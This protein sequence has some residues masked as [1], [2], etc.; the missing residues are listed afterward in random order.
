MKKY[1]NPHILKA[2]LNEQKEK[3]WD[4]R[5]TNLKITEYNSFR[6]I[7]YISLGLIKAKLK[8]EKNEEKKLKRAYSI[9]DSTLNS[10]TKIPSPN[11]GHDTLTNKDSLN[12]YSISKISPRKYQINYNNIKNKKSIY[13]NTIPNSCRKTKEDNINNKIIT[14]KYSLSPLYKVKNDSFKENNNKKIKNIL[15]DDIV[16]KI[17]GDE[18]IN[19]LYKEVKELWNEY[20]VSNIYQNK[21]LSSLNNYFL[22]KKLLYEFLIIEKNYMLK[23]KNEYYLVINKINQR[24]NEIE[25]IKKLIKEY[26]SKSNINLKEEIH[27]SLKLIRLY[28]INLV[29]QIKKFYLINSHLT[30]SGKIDLSKIKVNNFSF[31][32]KYI[33]T[34]K[35]DLDFLKYSSI[36]NLYNF[37][38][39]SNDPFLLSLSD[40]SEYDNN[41]K[42]NDLKY[43]TLPITDE[44]YNQII[45]L[46]YFMNQIEIN[47]KIQNNNKKIQITINNKNNLNKIN[48]YSDNWLT[49]NNELDIGSNYKGNLDKIINQLKIKNNYDELFLNTISTSKNHNYK[50]KRNFD[51]FKEI[52]YFLKKIKN[53]QK[54]SNNNNFEEIPITTA[55]QLQNKFKQYDEIKRLIDDDKNKKDIYT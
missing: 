33:S 12:N 45:K 36:K 32:Y 40:I 48:N 5:F 7:N 55:E 27:N 10:K 17:Q 43:E 46:L 38:N 16:M 2:S 42:T 8:Y 44:I 13:S 19:E 41:I 39:F 49:L 15:I 28:T 29:S 30:M 54:K 37:D 3:K 21:F 22:S 14:K 35:T 18:K 52:N 31:D 24:N 51:K 1:N 4:N 20:G 34:L 23:F 6:D 9:K 50:N 26:S 53:N 25:K 11:K 47:E